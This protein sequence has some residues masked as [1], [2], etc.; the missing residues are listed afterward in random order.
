[1]AL[2]N[3]SGLMYDSICF[4]LV[5]LITI[6][7]SFIFYNPDYLNYYYPVENLFYSDKIKEPI[8]CKFILLFLEKVF[9]TQFC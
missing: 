6:D 5:D 9:V 1:M 4:I 7:G 3:S 2:I 8:M